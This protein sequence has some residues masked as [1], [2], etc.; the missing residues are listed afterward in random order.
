MCNSVA[1]CGIEDGRR[2]RSRYGPER[3]PHSLASDT[4]P[5]L[6]LP[7]PRMA[8]DEL[9]RVAPNPVPARLV[10]DTPVRVLLPGIDGECCARSDLTY[11]APT[12]TKLEAQCIHGSAGNMNRLG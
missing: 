4:P 8:P 10:P 3:Q 9:H 2:V 1:L 5:D 11:D 6:P 7:W 12:R